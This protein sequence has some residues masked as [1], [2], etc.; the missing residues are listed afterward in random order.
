MSEQVND[1]EKDRAEVFEVH[2][3]YMHANTVIDSKLLAE[4]WDTDPSNVFFNLTG[5]NY[6]GLDH[7]TKLW[8]YYT[9]RFQA[10]F[11]WISYDHNI[12]VD[13]DVAWLTCMRVSQLGWVGEE[14]APMSTFDPVVS[15]GTEIYRR[16]DGQWKA[17]H[18]HYSPAATTPRPGNI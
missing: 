12:W 7:W 2:M 9:T 4:L 17:V 16:I 11:P 5:H 14:P 15:R 1:V 6:R 3:R 18:V 8:D 13:G 10:K